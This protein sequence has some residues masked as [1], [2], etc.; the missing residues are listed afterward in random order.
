MK[1]LS[2]LVFLCCYQF[3]W[4]LILLIKRYLTVVRSKGGVTDTTLVAD[5]R[6]NCIL[7]T[8]LHSSAQAL[9]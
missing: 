6:A 7:S 4:K 2:C 3:K 5:Y 1:G 9:N 8:G